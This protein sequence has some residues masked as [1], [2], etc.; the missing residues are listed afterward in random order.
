MHEKWGQPGGKPSFWGAMIPMS[1]D[2][3]P[4][5]RILFTQDFNVMKIILFEFIK[6][7]DCV[8][9]RYDIDRYAHIFA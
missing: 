6:M 5:V 2:E 8:T 7:S 9:K 1:L 4:L 3:T